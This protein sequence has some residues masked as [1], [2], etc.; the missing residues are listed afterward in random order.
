MLVKDQLWN[1]SFWTHLS[2]QNLCW[3]KKR[4]CA[5]FPPLW[6]E[7]PRCIGQSVPEHDHKQWGLSLHPGTSYQST[8]SQLSCQ[9]SQRHID[10]SLS[11]QLLTPTI[12]TPIMMRTTAATLITV[13]ITSV[14]IISHQYL[15]LLVDQWSGEEHDVSW[16][17]MDHH[18]LIKS[19]FQINN[20]FHRPTNDEKCDPV[21]D[22]SNV[23]H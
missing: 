5:S 4:T 15:L 23:S 19:V 13:I 18:C 2:T 9:I 10:G 8:T 3:Q 12:T 17:Q 20:T 1:W 16:T 7:S 6:T 14:V 22:G 21:E 11:T